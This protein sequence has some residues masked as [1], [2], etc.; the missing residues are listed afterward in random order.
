MKII[1]GMKKIKDLQ[2]KV[3]DLQSKIKIHCAYLDFEGETYENQKGKVLSWVQSCED[4]IQEIAKLRVAIQ[5]TNISTD[6]SIELGGVVVTKT[7]AEWIHRRR[8][9]ANLA[10]GTWN[11][12]TDKKLPSGPVNL[13]SGEVRQ[14]KPVLCFD[15]EE[16]DRKLEVYSSE[17]YLI[18]S[19]L[20]VINAIT[21]LIE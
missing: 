11:C 3:S 2:R 6:V 10:K 9:L 21:D 7:V 12:L 16:R 14:V 17:P 13:T 15:L 5:K 8:D 18:D 19:K 4:S 20:E 1:E